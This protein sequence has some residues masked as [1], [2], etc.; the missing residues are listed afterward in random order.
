MVP[1]KDFYQKVS[2]KFSSHGNPT[3]AAQM[4]KY[5]RNQ[6]EFY[7][8]PAPL[9]RSLQKEL[10]G[11]FGLPELTDLPELMDILWRDNH[12]ELQ[13]FGLDLMDKVIKKAKSDF[14][15]VLEKLI[16]T[17]SWW[18]SVDLLAIRLVGTHFRRFPELIS[19]YITK[20]RNSQNIWLQRTTI[21]FQLKYKRDTD[22]ELLFSLIRQFADSKEFFLQKA[23]GWALR[24]YSKTDWEAV[25]VF[26][27][28]HDLAPLTKREGL[29]WLQKRGVL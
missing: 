12:R 14:I 6:F 16:T 21:L 17:K 24:E 29:K 7:G 3:T 15:I 18:D 1:I 9:R 22:V 19:V 2:K 13:M 26:I 20:W 11:E 10:I 23:S 25:V 8:L 4:K 28:N 27:E 5:M